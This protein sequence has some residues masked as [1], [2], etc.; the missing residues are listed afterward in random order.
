M[1]ILVIFPT[2]EKKERH[3]W[4]FLFFSCI[5]SIL[6]QAKKNRCLFK[7]YQYAYR[8]LFMV[9]EPISKKK[10]IKVEIKYWFQKRFTFVRFEM[11]FISYLQTLPYERNYFFPFSVIYQSSA[12]HC[13]KISIGKER[14]ESFTSVEWPRVWY[15]HLFATTVWY[16]IGMQYIPEGITKHLCH[17]LAL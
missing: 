10:I 5:T 1:K 3:F 17:N 2:S 12:F 9:M 15:S 11:M 4:L 8:Y 13:D 16:Q 7:Y 14:F 6:Q